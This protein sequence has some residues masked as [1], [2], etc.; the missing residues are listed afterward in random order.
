MDFNND[1]ALDVV[2]T[3][4]VVQNPVSV[5]LNNGR[6]KFTKTSRYLPSV[7][8]GSHPYFTLETLDIDGD[9]HLDLFVGGHDWEGAPTLAFINPGNGNFSRAQKLKIPT[10]DGFGLVLDAVVSV[11]DNERSVWVLRTSGGDGT[12]YDGVA[13]QR[14]DYPSGTISVPLVKR[15]V[16]WIPSIMSWESNGVVYVGSDDKSSRIG[17]FRH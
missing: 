8:R 17:P 12:F 10:V 11:K 16:H 4:G 3:N 5:L 13:I 1:G 2:V 6:G 9:G 14:V 15:G 7:L